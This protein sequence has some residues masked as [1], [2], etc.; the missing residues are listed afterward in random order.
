MVSSNVPK[1]APDIID[2]KVAVQGFRDS[3]AQGPE[4][5]RFRGLGFRD[6][7]F[8][9]YQSSKAY[10]YDYNGF[11]RAVIRNFIRYLSPHGGMEFPEVNPVPQD[12]PI[13]QV[14]EKKE[15]LNP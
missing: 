15:T 6:L 13:S 5:Q 3:E 11:A 10:G 1:M 4:V 12:W 7:G 14:S 9:D 2:L 8:R